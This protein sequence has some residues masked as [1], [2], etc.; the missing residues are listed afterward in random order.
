[1]WL[2]FKYFGIL[3][4]FKCVRGWYLHDQTPVKALMGI[5]VICD[6][7]PTYTAVSSEPS[8]STCDLDQVG[9]VCK[10]VCQTIE[11]KFS[12]VLLCKMKRQT[13]LSL[14]GDTTLEP[15]YGVMWNAH[16]TFH[17]AR[18]HVISHCHVSCH[19]HCHVSCHVTHLV[20][21]ML[22]MGSLHSLT[23]QL[24]FRQS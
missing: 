10:V 2:L 6:H 19:V 3:H 17:L 16:L 5:H 1:M 4:Q 15:D 23:M 21:G 7:V 12:Y 14:C 8:N 13:M 24:T 11:K 20:H 9:Y 22:G 18:L